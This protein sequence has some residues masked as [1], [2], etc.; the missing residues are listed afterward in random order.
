MWL[1]IV[2]V[3]LNFFI[4]LFEFIQFIIEIW[5]KGNKQ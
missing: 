5:K 3:A 4:I 2:A 1:F